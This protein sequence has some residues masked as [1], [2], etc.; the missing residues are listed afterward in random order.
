MEGW[1]RWLPSLHHLF[2]FFLPSGGYPHF[3]YATVEIR[4]QSLFRSFATFFAHLRVVVCAVLCHVG[5][6]TFPGN[7]AIVF[8]AT[9]LFKYHAS[10]FSDTSI[11]VFAIFV[12][13]RASP[14]AAC[15]RC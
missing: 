3:P 15:L 12:A 13:D 8:T 14:L 11:V 1:N 7:G 10:L 4:S 6:A 2:C 9:F 5:C